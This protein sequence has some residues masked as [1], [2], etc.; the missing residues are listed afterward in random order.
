MTC[1]QIY[2]TSVCCDIVIYIVFFFAVIDENDV[3]MV[4]I[5]KVERRGIAAR[6]VQEIDVDHRAHGDHLLTESGHLL[7]LHLDLAHV[8]R[9][10]NHG[11]NLRRVLI[12]AQNRAHQ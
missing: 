4:A 8:R 12:V 7:G 6:E 11:R 1:C 9:G 3:K 10:R 2:E 5:E